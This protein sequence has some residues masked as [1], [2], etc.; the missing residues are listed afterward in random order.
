M[1]GAEGRGL[2]LSRLRRFPVG[3]CRAPLATTASSGFQG[4]T[5]VVID[6]VELPKLLH[7]HIE[8]SISAV[9]ASSFK[10]RFQRIDASTH[11]TRMRAKR[12]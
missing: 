4:S 7:I 8:Q 6:G 3:G 5:L 9:S 2:Q 11:W 1:T 12:C 10:I